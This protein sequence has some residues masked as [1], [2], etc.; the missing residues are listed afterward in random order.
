MKTNLDR[1]SGLPLDVTYI[2]GRNWRMHHDLAYRTAAGEE[3]LVR[4]GF[5]TDFASIPRLFWRLV[6]PTGD[7]GNPYGLAAVPHDWLYV[8]R[9]IGGR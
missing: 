7:T 6:P 8:H 5:V 1:F 9:R 3:V 2:D 4:A